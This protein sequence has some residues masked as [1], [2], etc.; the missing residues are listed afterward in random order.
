MSSLYGFQIKNQDFPPF[1]EIIFKKLNLCLYSFAF[2][3]K[4]D[5]FCDL[6]IL[7]PR[8]RFPIYPG[9]NITTY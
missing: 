4:A 6:R 1:A 7:D 8:F 3:E 2:L 5:F 9:R